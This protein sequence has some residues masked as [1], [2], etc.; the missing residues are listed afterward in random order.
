[1]FCVLTKKR[2]ERRHAVDFIGSNF[3]HQY[4]WAFCL[5]THQRVIHNV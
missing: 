4:I 5:I 2:N 3:I 1:L